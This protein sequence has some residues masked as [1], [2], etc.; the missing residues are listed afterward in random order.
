MTILSASF[1][2]YPAHVLDQVPSWSSA[3]K[4]SDPESTLNCIDKE[5]KSVVFFFPEES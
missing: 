1:T 2:D 3:F 5:L 4:L